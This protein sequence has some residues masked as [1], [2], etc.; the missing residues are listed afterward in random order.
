MYMTKIMGKIKLVIS[1]T[2]VFLSL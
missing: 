2:I 1:L